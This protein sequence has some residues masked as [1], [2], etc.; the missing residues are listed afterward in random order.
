MEPNYSRLSLCPFNYHL[1]DS[2]V[3]HSFPLY[4]PLQVLTEQFVKSS[5][6]GLQMMYAKLLEFVPHHCR[7]LREVTGGAI[8]RCVQIQ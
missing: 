3:T 5:P 8:S 1:V 6:S 4:A 7:L 2:S